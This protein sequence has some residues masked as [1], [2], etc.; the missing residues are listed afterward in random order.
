MWLDLLKALS[1]TLFMVALSGML[2]A[3]LGGSLGI[4]LYMTRVH[5]LKPLPRFYMLL[6]VGVN[7]TRSLPF[8]ILMIAVIPLTHSLTGTSIGTLAACVPLTLSAIPFAARVT[9]MALLEVPDSLI[10][11]AHAMGAS[12]LAIIKKVLLPEA[13]PGIIRGITI[14]LV[15]L[16]GYSAMAGTMGGGGLGDLA[17]NYGYQRFE[18]PVMAATVVILII[19]V[20]LLQSAGDFIANRLLTR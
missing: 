15:A 13:L 14:M 10:E 1:E 11:A 9:E 19:L 16:V 12:P 3:I 7:I 20:Q 18:L 8:V 4:V 6:S 17:I 2:A 5:G